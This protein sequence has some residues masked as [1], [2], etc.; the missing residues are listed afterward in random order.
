MIFSIVIS[1]IL[2][3]YIYLINNRYLLIYRL[4]PWYKGTVSA[5]LNFLN[6]NFLLHGNSR[7]D[8]RDEVTIKQR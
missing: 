8:V 4:F 1:N 3:I 6:V 5:A 7:Q 2:N